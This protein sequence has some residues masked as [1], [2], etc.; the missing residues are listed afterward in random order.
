MKRA[1][2]RCAALP[3]GVQVVS[4]NQCP[5]DCRPDDRDVVRADGVRVGATVERRQ[6][7]VDVLGRRTVQQHLVTWPDL[8]QPVEGPPE[9]RAVA[10]DRDIA[11]LSGQ[12]RTDVVA[13]PGAQRGRRRA[14]DDDHVDADRGNAQPGEAMADGHRALGVLLGEGRVVQ[15]PGPVA[16]FVGRPGVGHDRI[17]EHSDCGDQQH[18]GDH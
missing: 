11:G 9:R 6:S 8:V 1:I 15:L 3:L 4:V 5:G 14:L 13:G 7:P 10:S 17:G 12:R 2:S 16:L 18:G